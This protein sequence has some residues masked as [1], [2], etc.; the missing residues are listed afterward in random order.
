MSRP[1]P[2][3]VRLL[4]LTAGLAITLPA[5]SL[6]GAA[7]AW[8]DKPVNSSS[9][10]SVPGNSDHAQKN[11]AAAAGS[12]AA[13]GN[14]D[15]AQKSDAAA[16]V[17][18]D[19]APGNSD[20]AKKD[21]VAAAAAVTV[22]AAPLVTVTA[23]GNSD[24]SKGNAS[25]VGS[26][27]SPQPKSNA[28]KN[29]GGANNGGN[30]GDYCSTRNGSPSMN[31]NGGGQANGKPCAGC[32]GKA[33]NKNPPGQFKNGSDHNNGYECDGNHGVGK[34]NPAHTGCTGGTTGTTTGGTT[35]TTTGGDCDNKHG[36]GHDSHGNG[37]GNGHA[38]NHC[39]TTGGTTGGTTGTTTGGTTGTTTGGT[40]GTT[41]GGTTG[42]TTGGT[43]GITT[44][45]TS[46]AQTGGTTA[47]TTGGGGTGGGTV[48]P[49]RAAG[50]AGPMAKGCGVTGNSTGGGALPFTGLD[51]ASLLGIAL[52]VCGLGVGLTAAGSYRGVVVV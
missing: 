25:T 22:A 3:A 37:N 4:R 1:H 52:I 42:T 43:T 10:S 26:P 47:G 16:A 9:S 50:T 36:K 49:T 15:H 40:T 17:A 44:G 21:E 33:D 34:G 48:C 31:G 6:Y 13:P 45:G 39:T 14:S 8:A 18:N 19:A 28:D 20:H 7:G 32:V 27:T 46:G 51:V 5:V 29:P 38:K 41:T 23:P 35:G 12:D 11:D 30:C 2:L 24:H